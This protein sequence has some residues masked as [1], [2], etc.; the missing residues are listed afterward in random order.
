MN[1]VSADAVEV[2]EKI[3]KIRQRIK[4]CAYDKQTGRGVLKRAFQLYSDCFHVKLS[5][6]TQ[7]F[8]EEIADW[9]QGLSSANFEETSLES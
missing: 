7:L 9:K 8:D 5:E 3:L 1:E 2:A 6:L 4:A